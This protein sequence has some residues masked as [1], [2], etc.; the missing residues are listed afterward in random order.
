MTDKKDH[1]IDAKAVPHV[2]KS[3]KQMDT[4]DDAADEEGYRSR[5]PQKK[6]K[7]GR[8]RNP[9]SEQIHSKVRPET[10]RWLLDEARDRGVLQGIILEEALELY[11][12]NQNSVG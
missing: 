9:L 12:Q 10:K 6:T 5:E 11:R 8:P 3:S 7:R 1:W 2:V 4:L